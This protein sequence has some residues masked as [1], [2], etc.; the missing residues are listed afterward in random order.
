[1]RRYGSPARGSG[2][3][4]AREGRPRSSVPVLDAIGLLLLERLRE[5]VL[6]RSVSLRDEVQEVVVRWV[7]RTDERG[8]AGIADG[9]RRQAWTQVG[10]VRRVDLQIIQAEL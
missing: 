3:P 9:R 7:C 8:L 4:G 6:A 10:V 5:G 2:S 1:M